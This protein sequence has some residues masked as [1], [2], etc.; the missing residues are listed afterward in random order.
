MR[1]EDPSQNPPEATTV[2]V[3]TWDEEREGVGVDAWYR[4]SAVSSSEM[5]SDAWNDEGDAF[6]YR[7]A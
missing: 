4:R 6:A 5:R 1:Q 3:A 7:D 2:L